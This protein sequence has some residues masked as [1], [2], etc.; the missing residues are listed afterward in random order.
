MRYKTHPIVCQMCGA[1]TASHTA[2]LYC[3]GCQAQRRAE[4]D[5]RPE[6]RERKRQ[7][8]LE[9]W[10]RRKPK[11]TRPPYYR[12][13]LARHILAEARARNLPKSAIRAEL[14]L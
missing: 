2:R 5:A 8:A 9:S 3:T 12:V 14:G 7:S 4:Y 10:R 6:V 11:R 13:K 1:E